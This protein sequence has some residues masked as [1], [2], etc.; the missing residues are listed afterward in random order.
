[1]TQVGN[2]P[3]GQQLANAVAQ[4]WNGGGGPPHSAIDASLSVVGIDPEHFSG[5]N[6]E[7]KVREA[8]ATADDATAR[9]LVTE[10]VDLLRTEGAFENQADDAY[11]KLTRLRQA[12]TPAGAHLDSSGVLTWDAAAAA[13]ASAP[14]PT[15]AGG[16]PSLGFLIEVLR[17][18]PAASRPLVGTRRKGR[19]SIPVDDEYDVQD[20]V[21]QALKL[22]YADTRAEDPMPSYAGKSSR[23]DFFIKA[24]SI[25]IEVKVTRAGRGEREIRDEIIVDQ[26]AYQTHS[27]AKRLIAVV[28]DLANNFTNSAGFEDD[29]S[30][31]SAGLHSTVIVVPWPS[32]S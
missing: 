17:R 13:S 2:R 20:L 9:Y 18:L 19:P 8:L 15:A 5:F 11:R 28:Y 3:L 26:R 16:G 23:T 14:A 27:G 32:F 12:L 30:Q 24:E 4:L 21:H 1:M 31:H 25:V 10:L 29:L 22:L 7:R 6:K